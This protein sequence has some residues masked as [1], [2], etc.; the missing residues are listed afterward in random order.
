MELYFSFTPPV[1][2]MFRPQAAIIRQL[3]Y[4]AKT[5]ALYFSLHL[6]LISSKLKYINAVPWPRHS[7]GG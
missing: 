1:C 4:L 2:C 6:K 7:S 3:V 5:A